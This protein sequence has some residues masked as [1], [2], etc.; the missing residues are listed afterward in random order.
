MD[1]VGFEPTA[2][3]LRRSQIIRRKQLSEYLNIVE[4]KG[5][6]KKH[7]YETNR[8]LNHYLEYIDYKVDKS[9][10]IQYFRLLKDKYS[11]SSYRKQVYQILK[12]LR[13]LKVDWTGEIKLPSEP[14][15]YPKKVSGKDI[16]DALK[17]FE[18][19]EYYIRVK[20]LILLGS[21]SG[22]RAE[23]LYQLTTDNIDINNRT[24]YINHN[25]NN[26]QFTK[27][28]KSRV[29]FFNIQTQQALH[30]YINHFNSNI[31]LKVLF[32]QGRMEKLFKDA[33]I[34]VKDLRKFF[35]QEWDRKG[36]PTSIKKML[37][38]HSSD[39]DLCHYNAQNEDDLKLHFVFKQTIEL[40]K[41]ALST[42]KL[43]ECKQKEIG[44]FHLDEKYY[45]RKA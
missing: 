19:R 27:T 17:Y 21:T 33:P 15:Y 22:L 39:V 44:I 30:E 43:E 18:E 16:N 5:L 37:M 45:L 20:S 26:G 28:K 35:S 38:G 34:R 24:I 6:C 3:T 12:F 23:E 31:N 41:N 8:F 42:E 36:G 25:P 9:R 11:V 2:S 32:S 13:Y 40:P 4:L 1:W 10:S 29:S 14:T 7:I